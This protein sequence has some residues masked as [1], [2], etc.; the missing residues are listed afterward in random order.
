MDPEGWAGFGG[1]S[2]LLQN[3]TEWLS[4]DLRRGG[5]WGG[6]ILEASSSSCIKWRVS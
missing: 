1:C 3:G 2:E 4:E 5:G 6:W